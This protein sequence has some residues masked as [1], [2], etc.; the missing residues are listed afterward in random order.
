[1]TDQQAAAFVLA[2]VLFYIVTQLL[3][4]N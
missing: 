4:W 1:M 2:I 3:G